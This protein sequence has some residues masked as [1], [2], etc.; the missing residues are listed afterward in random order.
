MAKI[1]AT[2][3]G[4]F[5]RTR[6]KISVF[7]VSCLLG[8]LIS[9]TQDNNS[10]TDKPTRQK[11]L[12][13]KK[14][15]TFYN[16][17]SSEPENLH[18][19]RSTDLYSRHVQAYVLESLLDRN[20]D[21]YEWEPLLAKKWEVSPDGKYFVFELHDDL[22]WSDGKPLTVKDVKFSFE[23]RK[24]KAYG[25]ITSLP[26][27]EKLDSVEIIGEKKIKVHIN[28]PYFGNFRVI[29]GMSVIPEHIYKDPTLKLS[30]TIIGSGPYVIDRYIRGK[31]IVL[32]KNPLW[33]D[34]SPSSR[35]GKWQF[36]TVVFR[37][38]KEQVDAILKM[39]KKQLDYTEL[40][41]ESFF[42]KTNHSPWGTQIRKVKYQNS[43]PS[44][45]SYVG[46]N[47]RNPIFQ[48]KR[49]RKALAHLFNR[50]LMNKKFDHNQ[51]ELAR[52]PWY[53]WNEYADPSVPAIE[54]DPQK[55]MSLL[56]LAGWVDRNKN[57]VLDKVV[58]GK[59]QELAFSITYSHSSQ[60]EKYLTLYQEALKQVGVQ[61]SLKVLDWA[62]FLRL[63]DD[64]NFDAVMLGW[65]GG[66]VDVDP[67]QIWHS[68]SARFKGS[69]FIGYS[70]PK[71][72]ALIDKGRSQLNKKKRVEIFRKVYK[73]IAE[74]VPYL[75]LFNTR[76]GFYAV[77]QRISTPVDTFK[78]DLGKHYW[79]LQES[80]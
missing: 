63:L 52:G 30:K 19:I 38:V 13:I 43:L 59:T 25:G 11:E 37:F 17:L 16:R 68:T 56:N 10:S 28:E 61:L 72:D 41:A 50:K 40:T 55:A 62:S 44:G 2:S 54:F 31:M 71:V 5:M 24:D 35:Q 15:E 33:A 77:N 4:Y 9:C 1:Q 8:G 22:K 36:K 3:K 75:F 49:V 7:L 60:S 34:R 66:S 42:Q 6:E 45:Y 80:P 78:Y 21:T 48:D 29:A 73:L 76:V 20:K 46:F 58:N 69:N 12:T 47:L 65:G 26:Y 32:K 18:P 67:K 14:G 64:K 23:A 74:D 53:F 57:G 51:K 27:F 79:S 70:N 39:E